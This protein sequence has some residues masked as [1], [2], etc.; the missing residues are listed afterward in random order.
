[1]KSLN[2]KAK[3]LYMRIYKYKDRGE[4]SGID[5]WRGEIVTSN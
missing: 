3:H 4:F 2:F 5:D 1:M